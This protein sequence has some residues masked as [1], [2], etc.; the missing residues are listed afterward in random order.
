MNC[1]NFVSSDVLIKN[2]GNCNLFSV[3]KDLEYEVHMHGYGN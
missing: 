3:S 1:S 2:Y